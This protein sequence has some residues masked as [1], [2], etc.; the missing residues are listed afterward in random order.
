MYFKYLAFKFLAFVSK[1]YFKLGG[2]NKQNDNIDK[3]QNK[4]SEDIESEESFNKQK[5]NSW[6]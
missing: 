3:I 5:K 6:S 2:K 1:I 4:E